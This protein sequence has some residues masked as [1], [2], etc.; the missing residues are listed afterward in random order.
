MARNLGVRQSRFGKQI[1]VGPVAYLEAC[2]GHFLGPNEFRVTREYRQHT[3]RLGQAIDLGS[4]LLSNYLPLGRDCLEQSTARFGRGTGPQKHVSRTLP[5]QRLK[6][7]VPFGQKREFHQKW[8]AAFQPP[9]ETRPAWSGWE[10]ALSV[11]GL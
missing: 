3:Y 9:K 8:K 1:L 2:R 10:N 4:L 11:I 6:R 5:E 7:P